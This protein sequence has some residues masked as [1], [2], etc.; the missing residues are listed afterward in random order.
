M[1]KPLARLSQEKREKT[2]IHKI[3]HERDVTTDITDIQ[4]IILEYC[5]SLYATKFNNLEEMDKCLQIY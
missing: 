1:N 4:S 2:Q 3:R 5:E